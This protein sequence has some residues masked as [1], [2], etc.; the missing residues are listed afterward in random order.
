MGSTDLAR[1]NVDDVQELESQQ[2]HLEGL[3]VDPGC[4]SG[5]MWNPKVGICRHRHIRHAGFLVLK[6]P[7]QYGL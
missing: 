4:F 1:F 7:Y 3:V 6:R 5:S 2:G